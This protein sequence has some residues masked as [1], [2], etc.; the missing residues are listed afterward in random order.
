MSN[1]RIAEEQAVCDLIDNDLKQAMQGMTREE[2][3][4]PATPIKARKGGG[5]PPCPKP[6]DKGNSMAPCQDSDSLLDLSP[7][8]SPLNPAGHPI[9]YNNIEES[10]EV[11]DIEPIDIKAELS[12][13][14]QKFIQLH[15]L[16]NVPAL[17]ALVTAGYREYSGTY[18]YVVAQKIIKKYECRADTG[19]IF[20]NHNFGAHEIARGIIHLAINCPNA[21]VRLNALALCAKA[22][23]MLRDQIDQAPGVTIIIKGRNSESVEIGGREPSI[24][25]KTTHTKEIKSDK[26]VALVR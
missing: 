4:L 15:L 26:P 10:I 13:K 6:K 24:L 5:K 12:E 11:K 22:V 21:Q 25:H 17:T 19:E 9:V 20:S 2:V 1:P 16:G 3:I 8:G 7:S 23:G 14:E 18:G